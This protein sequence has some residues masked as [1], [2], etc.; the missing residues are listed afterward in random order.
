M[1]GWVWRKRG[2]CLI[3][4]HE[5]LMN[6]TFFLICTKLIVSAMTTKKSSKLDLFLRYILFITSN[7]QFWIHICFHGMCC[8][9]WSFQNIFLFENWKAKSFYYVKYGSSNISSI[10]LSNNLF[11]FMSFQIFLNKLQYWHFYTVLVLI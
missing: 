6:Q 8:L 4:L 5:K 2:R 9:F 7:T 11:C 10:I 3:H 1:N